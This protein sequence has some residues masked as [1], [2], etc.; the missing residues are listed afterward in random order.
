MAIT[1]SRRYYRMTTH[2]FENVCALQRKITIYT[3]L[4][5]VRQLILAIKSHFYSSPDAKY[6]SSY[7]P[8]DLLIPESWFFPGQSVNYL[9]TDIFK[10]MAYWVRKMSIYK[11]IFV[12]TLNRQSSVHSK[13]RLLIVKYKPKLCWS[14]PNILSLHTLQDNK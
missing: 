5:D 14:W 7:R 11:I 9:Y 13:T 6:S 10:T 1:S 8:T 4:S 12:S 3:L 2:K